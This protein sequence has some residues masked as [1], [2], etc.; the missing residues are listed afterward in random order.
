MIE[1]WIARQ[2]IKGLLRSLLLTEVLELLAAACFP[3]RNRHDFLLVILVN[4]LT[5]PVVVYLDFWLHGATIAW[6]WL[7][8]GG[9]EFAVWL[10]ETLI[11]RKCLIIFPD[12][13][14]SFLSGRCLFAIFFVI[15]IGGN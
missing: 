9:L 2:L 8:V 14:C 12:F 3:Q 5:N 13:K 7:W 11:Y 1:A 4:I 15:M 6:R 10:S